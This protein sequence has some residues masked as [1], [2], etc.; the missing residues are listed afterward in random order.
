MP[1]IL[2]V[3]REAFPDAARASKG[4]DTAASAAPNS[5][6]AD[7]EQIQ[8]ESGVTGTYSS[9]IAAI[10]AKVMCANGRMRLRFGTVTSLYLC[11]LQ[12][13]ATLQDADQQQH[14][15]RTQYQQATAADEAALQ[16]ADVGRCLDVSPGCNML[17]N[18]TCQPFFRLY[19]TLEEC[20]PACQGI[21]ACAGSGTDPE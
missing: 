3:L 16:Q 17:C 13:L 19:S 2:H 18:K 8:T 11:I 20:W 1:S 15:L 10:K 12:H 14:Y 5:T 6:Q 21:S 4:S 7:S 9:R